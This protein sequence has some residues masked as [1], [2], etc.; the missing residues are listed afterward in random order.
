MNH[1]LIFILLCL[2]L[3]VLEGMI[4]RQQNPYMARHL[5]TLLASNGFRRVQSQF[6]SLPLGWDPVEEEEDE[7]T[8]SSSNNIKQKQQSTTKKST[9]SNSNNN[10]NTNKKKKCSELAR[11]AASQ[12]LFLLQSLRPWLSLVM[13]LNTEKFNNHIMGLPE[14]WRLGQTYI[15]WHC[16]TAQKPHLP[17]Y[18]H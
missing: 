3:L 14:S 9:S 5:S 7:P 1:L 4:R 10:T 12:H 11:L 15:N 2:L 16:A 8:S 17:H 18:H 13:N 6:Q